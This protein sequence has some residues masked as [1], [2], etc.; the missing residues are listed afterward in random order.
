M[1][2]P[3]EPPGIDATGEARSAIADLVSAGGPVMFF[4]SGGG[5]DGSLPMCLERSATVRFTSI[6][7]STRYGREPG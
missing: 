3:P 4:Q 6:I 2:G 5:C 1:T 7:D